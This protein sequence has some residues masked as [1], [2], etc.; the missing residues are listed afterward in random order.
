VRDDD[1]S[2]ARFKIKDGKVVS[3]EHYFESPQTR[4]PVLE[5]I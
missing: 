1:Q 5:A 3:I 4:T 2:L